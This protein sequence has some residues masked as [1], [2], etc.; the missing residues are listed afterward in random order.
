MAQSLPHP[1][2]VK[3]HRKDFK[4]HHHDRYK[5]LGDE[6]RKPK[7]IDSCVRRRFRG[8]IRMPKVGYGS[9]KKTRHLI[10]S[11]HK[12][13]VVS[14]ASEL[15]LLLLQT[16]SHAAEIAHNVSARKR[17]ELVERAKALGVKV[18][19][20]NARLSLEA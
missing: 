20:P 7:G 19:N 14:N 8:T 17:V 5:R 12:V 16:K 18:T 15:E 1:T 4:R 11:G 10:P 2:I 3:K 6:W 9:N 13:F